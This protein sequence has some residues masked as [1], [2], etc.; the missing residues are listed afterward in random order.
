MV[1]KYIYIFKQYLKQHTHSF[2][3]SPALLSQF[4]SV[5]IGK[6]GVVAEHFT[7][8]CSNHE[9]LHLPLQEDM[10]HL[11]NFNIYVYIEY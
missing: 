4:D 7:V 2:F 11:N 1:Q 6:R 8:D 9:L 3:Q 5:N 10:K